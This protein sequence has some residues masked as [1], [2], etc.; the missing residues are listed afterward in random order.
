MTK[1]TGTKYITIRFEVVE[2][3]SNDEFLEAI[4]KVV[5][6]TLEID[7]IFDLVVDIQDNDN[8]VE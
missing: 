5:H 4:T 7:R 6:E 3:V 2:S 8:P 1:E